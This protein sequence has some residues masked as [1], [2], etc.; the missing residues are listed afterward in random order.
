MRKIVCFLVMFWGMAMPLWAVNKGDVGAAES[1]LRR[2]IPDCADMFQFKKV[3]SKEDFF[4][5]ESSADSKILISGNNANSMAVGLNY[6]LK[7][8]CLTT[9][10]WYA[11]QSVEMPEVLPQI[12]SPVEVKAR[13]ERRFFLNYCTFGY[14]MAFWDWKDWQRFIDWMALNGVN[15]PLAI[16]GQEAVWYKVWKDMGLKSQEILSY[17]TGPVYLPWHRMANID[18]WNGPLPMEWLEKQTKLQQQIL[19]RERELNMK[20]VLPAFNGHVPA[21]LKRVYPDADI[22][23]LGNWAGF[24]DEYHCSFLSPEEPLFATIQKK[25]LKEQ[26]RLFGTDHIYGVDPFNEVEP[27]SWEPDYLKKVSS[28]LYHTLLNADSK[29]EWLQMTWMF[30]FDKKKWTTPRVEAFLKGVPV[31][32]LSLLDYHCE[33]VEL[34]KETD[35]FY[36]QPYIWCYLGNFGGNTSLVGSVKDSGDRL[37]KALS[38]GGNNL[39]GIG[40]TLEGLDVIQFP[41]EYILEKAWSIGKDNQTWVNALADRHAGEVSQ[42]VREAWNLLFNDIYVQVSKTAGI[43]PNYRPVMGSNCD[44]VN[45]EYCNKKLLQVWEGLLQA[46][47][48]KRDALQLDVISVGRQLLGNYFLTVKN[49]FDRMYKTGDL[50]AL[51][52]RA[53]EMREILNDIDKLTFF[54]NYTSLHKWIDMARMYSDD[55]AIQDYYEKNARSLITTWGG[56]LNDYASRTW[57]GLIGGY[58]S[59]RWE[60]YI[61]AV[62]RSVENGQEFNQ[63]ILDDALD[64]FESD[65]VDS[66]TKPERKMEGEL[67]A[68]A[69]Y[70]LSK[71]ETRLR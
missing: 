56:I 1:M 62:V 28:N 41:Y 50:L 69:R 32:R 25:F 68:F 5:I 12:P 42:P 52:M 20:P 31:N 37:E 34:W 66:K 40:S 44:N 48:L 24:T 17:F 4:R 53:L 60:M 23:S 64:K 6:Y 7:Y 49:E 15:M 22:Q 10:S 8:Y 67:Q 58:Y 45:I 43:L 26:E 21:A 51:R 16:T 13:V 61:D 30:Y 11:D 33:K 47:D 36:G 39:K 46:S 70:L 71:Y 3:N 54:H 55:E 59:V 18:S 38:E 63:K 29:A 65:W 27:P 9:V 57:A 2:L 19:S 35:C 14:S